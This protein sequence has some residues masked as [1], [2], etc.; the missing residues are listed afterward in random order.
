MKKIIIFSL[1]IGISGLGTLAQAWVGES[2]ESI[3]AKVRATFSE[4]PVMVEVARCESTFRQL[5]DAGG[6]FRGG[7]GGGYLGIFQIGESLHKDVALQKG[8]DILTV[9]GNIG[10]AKYMYDREGTRP[11]I[12][13]VPSGS[14]SSTG[15]T[16]S[17]SSGSSS[18]STSSGTSSGSTGSSNSSGPSTG[19]PITRNLQPGMTHDLV[20][21][22]QKMLNENG[23][24]IA[25]SGAGSPGNETMYYGTKTRVAVEKFQCDQNV[26]C[27]NQ[28]G[29]GFFGP[30]TRAAMEKF[31]DEN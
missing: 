20:K 24:K 22:L 23:Y 16:S 6:V 25:E 8:F 18:G 26:V 4:A 3:E 11:W 12:G 21:V 14:S 17:G 28:T 13:C 29:Y 10:Y 30:K 7:T 19:F 9:D 15:S 2:R 31:L 1:L 5:N 27:K